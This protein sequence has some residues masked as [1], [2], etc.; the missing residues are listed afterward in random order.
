M[1]NEWTNERD[2]AEDSDKFTAA[3][4]AAA[5]VGSGKV[6]LPASV[7]MAASQAVDIYHVVLAE[8][9]SRNKQRDR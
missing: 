3:S 7:E 6:T 2:R 4:L 5:L 8:L 9:Q 1:T